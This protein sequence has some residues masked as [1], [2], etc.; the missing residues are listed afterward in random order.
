MT[1]EAIIRCGDTVAETMKRMQ[2]GAPLV[3]FDLETTGLKKEVD[4]ILSFS[5][6]KLV[7]TNDGFKEIDRIDQFIDPEM[8][9]PEEVTEINHISAETVAGCPTEEEAAV[10]IRKFFGDDP[11]VAGYNSV[12][13]DEGFVNAMYLRVFGEPFT[14]VA[15]LD[16]YRMAK[17]KLDLPKHKLFMVAHELGA[18]VGIEFHNSIDD[19]IAT[20]RCMVVL[21]DMYRPKEAVVKKRRVFVVS[22]KRWTRSHELDRI[23]VQT[24]PYSKTYYDVYKK[25]WASDMDDLDFDDLKGQIFR[26]N[27]CTNELEM[28]RIIA[29]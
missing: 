18:D 23:Y 24:Q 3:V 13:F 5:A 25:V 22:A 28:A 8:D 20:F 1:R 17:E 4:R 26:Q 11:L 15:H 12:S 9:I 27:N 14:P 10:I 6:I 16:V 19:V 29:S 2:E 7:K 21:L